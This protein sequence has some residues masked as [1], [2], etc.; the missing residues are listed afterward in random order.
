MLD[1]TQNMKLFRCFGPRNPSPEPTLDPVKTSYTQSGT[2]SPDQR[3]N[4]LGPVQHIYRKPE[5]VHW[6]SLEQQSAG[7][8][9]TV[10]RVDRGDESTEMRA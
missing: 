5:L 1:V 2:N 7:V 8:S 9:R 6:I 10:G 4:H 3:L